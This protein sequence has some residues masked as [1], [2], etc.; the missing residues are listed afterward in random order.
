MSKRFGRK[1]KRLLLANLNYDRHRLNLV[2]ALLRDT[3]LTAIKALE[4]SDP[5]NQ[6]I[7]DNIKRDLIYFDKRAKDIFG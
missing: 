5:A 4:I 3:M 7:R 6:D 1:R 2:N